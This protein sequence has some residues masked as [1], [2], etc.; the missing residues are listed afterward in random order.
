[1][2]QHDFI[3]ADA[4]GSAFLADLNLAVKAQAENNS[5]TTAPAVMYAH[6]WWADTTADILKQR[7]AANTGWLNRYTLSTGA[8]LGQGLGTPASGVL[9]NCTGTAPGFT[10]GA[11][12]NATNVTGS[13]VVSGAVQ[14]GT[15]PKFTAY[16][17]SSQNLTADTL[18]K[19]TWNAEE[20]DIGSNFDSATN[21]R[22]TAPVAGYYEFSWYAFI[23]S[24]TDSVTNS[25]TYFYKNGSAVRYG[26]DRDSTEGITAE[27][28]ISSG[29]ASIY[30]AVND[31][32]EIFV[33]AG[34]GG[35]ALRVSG[36]A[37]IRFSV[38]SGYLV[39]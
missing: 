5:G 32:V 24:N 23:G 17:S 28:M 15:N 3:L 1:M 4:S 26:T 36:D 33:V 16:L 18:T 38:F 20:Y 25:I 7:N 37:S 14:S 13:A 27:N 2:S 30:L 9:T 10:A 22:F 19:I 35:G 6:M 29:S 39:P 11:A 31:Y 21:H 34:G 12:T 8:L